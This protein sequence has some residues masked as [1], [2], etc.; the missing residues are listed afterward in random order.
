MRN[1]SGIISRKL[2]VEWA[3][4]A[5]VAEYA[6][7]IDAY[8]EKFGIADGER[9]FLAEN[10]PIAATRVPGNK[11]LIGGASLIWRCLFGDGTTSTGQANT[12]LDASNARICVGDGNP[13]ALSGTVTATNASTTIT[14]SASQTGLIDNY[15]VFSGDSTGGVYKVVSGSGTNWTLA[16]N[17]AGSTASGMIASKIIGE[18]ETQ[19]DLQATTN[20]VRQGM[21]S[22]FP[23]H[24]AGSGAQTITGATN[25]SPIVVTCSNS[26]AEGDFVLVTGVGGNTAANGIHRATSVSGTGFT[27]QGSVGNGA[28]TSGGIAS[29]SR[30]ITYQATFGSGVAEYKWNE[31]GLANA[32]SGGA[33]VNRKVLNLGSKGPGS[34][35]TL[36]VG[37]ALT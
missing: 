6:G 7:D 15:L 20:K 31:W 32:A 25:A 34:S 19:T 27:L 29:R 24:S 33:M 13:A 35:W 12:Y 30:V 21:D 16:S 23:K 17:Y 4:A 1:T 11:L 9:R 10:A 2:G 14:F 3:C 8:R 28:Y 18:V 5:V 37:V 36:A 22:G 26:Y